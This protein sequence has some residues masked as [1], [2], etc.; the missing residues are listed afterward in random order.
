MLVVE[1]LKKYFVVK[2]DLLGRPCELVKAVD[3]VSF[4]LAA[5][6]TLGIV[7]E[8]GSGKTT[9]ARTLLHLYTPDGGAIALDGRD[10]S[11]LDRANES[12]LRRSVQMVFQNPYTSLDERYRV[13]ETLFEAMCL[14]RDLTRAD[15]LKLVRELMESVDLPIELVTRY[16]HELSG[17]QRQRV[18]IAR[19][20][21]ARPRLLI[22]DEPT[23]ALDAQNAAGIIKLLQRLQSERKLGYIFISHDLRLVSRVCARIIVMYRGVIVEEA[24]ADVI[25]NRPLHPY[26]RRLIRAARHELDEESESDLEW[27]L[28]GIHTE[29]APGHLVRRPLITS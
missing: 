26:T 19:A 21:A 9:V 1:E 18:C 7:G 28:E 27:T 24:P 29:V 25:W 15:K 11:R 8:S 6:E 4:T 23:S 2:K 13:E 3:G 14:M 5:G 12:V 10:F 22:L 17:G 20:L 16:P